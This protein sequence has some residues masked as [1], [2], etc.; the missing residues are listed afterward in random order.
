[1]ATHI[2][3]LKPVY[4]PEWWFIA[5]A[6][7]QERGWECEICHIIQGED[8]HNNITVH[9][10]DHN[11]FNNDPANLLVACQKCHLR[12][13]GIYRRNRRADIPIAIALSQGQKIMPAFAHL[14]FPQPNKLSYASPRQSREPGI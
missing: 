13:E 10:K 8:P 12:L 11:T 7:K 9:H 5:R 1:M 4:P 6:I 14:M 2:P 3:K